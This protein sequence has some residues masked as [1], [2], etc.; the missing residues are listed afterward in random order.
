LLTASQDTRESEKRAL[1][2]A[3]LD[4]AYEKWLR[5]HHCTIAQDKSLP[6]LDPFTGQVFQ[7][8]RANV[9]FKID[10]DP[11]KITEPRDTRVKF[12]Q[13]SSKPLESFEDAAKS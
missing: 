1:T 6:L 12:S 13:E 10:F 2:L 8:N 11:V 7:G 5:S 9:P 4:S 3:D